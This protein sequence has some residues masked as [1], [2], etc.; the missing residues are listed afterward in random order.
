MG[1][2]CTV[3]LWLRASA[4]PAD[5]E[6]RECRHL[7][8]KRP[9]QG[10]LSCSGAHSELLRAA[11]WMLLAYLVVGG[12]FSFEFQ[13]YVGSVDCSATWVSFVSYECQIVTT[14]N[15]LGGFRA[16]CWRTAHPGSGGDPG[17]PERV[18]GKEAYGLLCHR[19]PAVT[20]AVRVAGIPASNMER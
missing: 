2:C 4:S 3:W 12:F 7:N 6:S 10:S 20:L 11:G 9:I 8:W 16:A 1:C 5:G 13:W 18:C 17:R 15:V 19:S 14:I